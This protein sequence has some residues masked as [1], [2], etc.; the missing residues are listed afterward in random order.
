MKS[1]S[2]AEEIQVPVKNKALDI[3][4][5]DQLREESQ[6]SVPS[7]VSLKYSSNQKTKALKFFG[8]PQILGTKVKRFFG[9]TS[10][11]FEAVQASNKMAA[12]ERQRIWPN[13]SICS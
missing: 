4:G 10:G 9:E 6:K 13:A 1:V 11:D 7:Q 5:D 2:R 12:K 3:L 8:E